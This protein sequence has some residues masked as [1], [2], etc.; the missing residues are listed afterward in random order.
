MPVA[1]T[2]RVALYYK[3][4][5][6]AGAVPGGNGNELRIRSES[7]ASPKELVESDEIVADAQV[8]DIVEIYRRGTGQIAVAHSYGAH[9]ALL[10]AALRGAFAGAATVAA[11]T[12]ISAAAADNSFNDSGAGFGSLTVG[13]WIRV[14]GFATN[15]S[16]I[17]C[18]IVT[19]P[20]NSKITVAGITLVNESAGPSVV[21]KQGDKLSNGTTPYFFDFE[22]KSSDLT[23]VFEVFRDFV[24]DTFAFDATA[25]QFVQGT[26]GVVGR[27]SEPGTS[28]VMGT[29]V[30]S[31]ANRVF[32]TKDHPH[33]FFEGA[34]AAANIQRL[35]ALQFT[36]RVGARDVADQGDG[37]PSDMSTGQFAVEGSCRVYFRGADPWKTKFH[38][39]T[40][41]AFYYVLKDAAKNCLIVEIPLVTLGDASSPTPGRNQ[42]AIVQVAWRASKDPVTG[43]TLLLHR[44]PA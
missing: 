16:V 25:K 38:A 27:T 20:S 10:E 13:S 7:L 42:D 2:D 40:Q 3:R 5:S 30:A 22:R 34:V 18:K 32:N 1:Q 12:T 31:P 24:V 36:T 39:G 23:N 29:P 17:V 8:Q 44:I 33:R 6:A 15:G 4:K 41:T 35:M 9:D 28:T 26:F 19:K 14:D 37:G 21:I 43:A 11:A